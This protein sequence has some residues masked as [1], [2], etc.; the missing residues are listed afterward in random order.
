MGGRPARAG[1]RRLRTA[2]ITPPR[3]WAE[4]LAR[5]HLEALGWQVSDANVASRGGE[6]DL[7][8]RDG[9]TVVFVE[10]RQRRNLRFGHPGETI[11]H[12]K[13][14]RW[15]AAA[16]RYLAEKVGDADA[17]SRFDAILVVGDPAGAELTH[18][19]DVI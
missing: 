16:R 9:A 8:A 12:A 4:V 15:V 19:R 13:L 2:A 6:I 7:V 18:L 11:D 17:P 10:V 14:R 5:R 3:H 1:D